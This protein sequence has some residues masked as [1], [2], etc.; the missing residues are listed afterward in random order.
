MDMFLSSRQKRQQIF[1][2]NLF[3]NIL[4]LFKLFVVKPYPFAKVRL[5]FY[6]QTVEQK[7]EYDGFFKFEWQ[8]LHD[9]KRGGTM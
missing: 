1:S 2:N 3:V 8:A 6:S 5:H 4:H 9:V 7:A